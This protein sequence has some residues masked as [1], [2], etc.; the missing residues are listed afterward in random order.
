MFSF[1][2]FARIPRR[3]F[4]GQRLDG[5]GIK[6]NALSIAIGVIACAE[7]NAGALLPY[8]VNLD[9]FNLRLNPQ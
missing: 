7:I 2:T 9:V 5:N 1:Y 4:I 8:A 6:R 3:L